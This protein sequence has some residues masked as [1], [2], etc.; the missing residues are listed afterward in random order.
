[1]LEKGKTSAVSTDDGTAMP[2]PLEEEK[3]ESKTSLCDQRS[4]L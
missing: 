2:S 3:K 4:D 1:M